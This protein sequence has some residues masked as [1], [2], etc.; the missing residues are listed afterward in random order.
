MD[1]G[2]ARRL[3][4]EELGV[5]VE[6]V[7]DSASFADDLGADSLDFVELTMRFE[8]A[9]DIAVTEDEAHACSCVGDAIALLKRKLPLEWAA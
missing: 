8:E 6:R 4:A 2:K 7:R 3:I 1:E 9:F 5:A